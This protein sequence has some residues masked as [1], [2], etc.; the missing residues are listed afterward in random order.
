MQ[1]EVANARRRHRSN[2]T[3]LHKSFSSTRSA[4]RDSRFDK[5]CG[6]AHLALPALRFLGSN[7]IKRAC[8]MKIIFAATFAYFLLL[9]MLGWQLDEDACQTIFSES[10]I[11]EKFSIVAWITA[12]LCLLIRHSK[13]AP[14]LAGGMS[15]LCFLC[16]AREDDWHK[17]FTADG[18]L[19]L[20]YYTKT[21]APL[22]EKIPAAL[23]ALIFL[24]LI[25][26]ATYLAYRCWRLGTWRNHRAQQLTIL[27]IALFFVS[28]TLDRS[29]SLLH[30]L[31]QIDVSD[32]IG[33][34]IGAYEEGFEM[35]SPLLFTV[36]ALWPRTVT[37]P[38]SPA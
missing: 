5:T 24:A 33:R 7:G 36:A 11:F 20:K 1:K 16:A 6:T 19:K 34:M 38:S 14:F 25:F 2:S 9:T 37:T 27:G 22:S 30:E 23:I 4:R 21:V 17:K 8:S 26:Y 12:G 35:W 32:A 15:L 31:A 3:A 28:K 18:I 13:S 10:G 29:I